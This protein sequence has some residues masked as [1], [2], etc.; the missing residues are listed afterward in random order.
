M[1][2]SR[3]KVVARGRAALLWTLALFAAG[4]WGMGAWLH[5]R[6][7]E[8]CEPTWEL[9]LARLRQ[10]LAEA[11]G[12]PLLIAL[13]S[14]RA[15]NGI[16]P[17]DL[18]DWA[19]RNGPKPVAFNFATL[20]AGPIRE[21]LTLRRLL[22]HGIR[23]DWLVVE[24][25]PA[26]WLDKG[27]YEEHMPILNADSHLSDLPVLQRL[28]RCG[29]GTFAK[30]VETNA[31]P[32]VHART[33]LFNEYAP[34]LVDRAAEHDIVWARTH[35]MTLDDWGWL[36]VGWS[37]VSAE[38]FRE[39]L[40]VAYDVT[41]PRFDELEV[42]ENTDWAIR[43]LLRECRR[44]GTRVAFLY[45]PEHSVLRSWYLPQKL[46]LVQ[47]YLTRLGHDYG[48]PIIDLHDWLSDDCFQDALH[49]HPQGARTF[50]ARFGPEI[51]RPLLEGAPLPAHA[52]L[53]LHAAG[54]TASGASP[55]GPGTTSPGP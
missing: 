39:H 15:A 10:R 51:L 6:H 23:P 4:Q 35:W 22:A 44:R 26:F 28:Y 41:K 19:P 21:L 8:M 7:P 37:R 3:K 38:E 24:V 16:S 42:P 27:H 36:P 25:W 53:H 52:A 11:P 47:D 30:I 40:K 32:V 5:H 34:F 49:L 48:L 43:E 2:I 1:T 20:G 46:A 14:S 17:A 12:R 13:G 50:S 29:W 33:E 55:V 9:R 45:M 18:G 54:G 31:V